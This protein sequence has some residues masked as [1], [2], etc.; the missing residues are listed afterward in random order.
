MLVRI[1]AGLALIA[2]L[3]LA[4]WLYARAWAPSRDDYPVQGVTIGSADGPV[5]WGTL[6]AQGADFAYIRA[7]RAQDGRDPAFAANWRGAR[8]AGMR[9]GAVIEFSACRSPIDQATGFMTT[10]PRDNAALPPV[11]RLAF[12]AGCAR[13]P[14][15]DLLLSNL[16]TL[17][18]LVEG[19]AGKPALL[20]V[21]EDFDAAYDIGS[22]I[23]RTLW[24]DGNFFPPDYAS[25]PWVMWTATNMRHI[26]GVDGPVRWN[27]VAR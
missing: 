15:R 18:N 19:Q 25:R 5:D 17:I 14:G 7:V 12:S 9:Y 22:G 13:R 27:V 3:A 1:G 2:M 6:A 11:I 10:V 8:A 20:N 23:N 16:N 21:S 26:D 24:L 4:L